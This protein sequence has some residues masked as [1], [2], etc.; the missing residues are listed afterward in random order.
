MEIIR[1]VIRYFRATR[2]IYI[3]GGGFYIDLEPRRIIEIESLLAYDNGQSKQ[4]ATRQD[5]LSYI[6][7]I[8]QPQLPWET[9]EKYCQII[10]ALIDEIREYERSLD[11]KGIC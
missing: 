2:Y 10:R 11:K 9:K 1:F 4:F 5:Y 8:S 3:R 6:S 7:D